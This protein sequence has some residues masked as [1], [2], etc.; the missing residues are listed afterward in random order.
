MRCLAW[1]PEGT[2]L[3]MHYGS[4]VDDRVYA[5]SI[6]SP[7]AAE[8]IASMPVAA[9]EALAAPGFL[10]CP[11]AIF[12]L[13][14]VYI[15]ACVHHAI[16]EWDYRVGQHRLLG[17]S[18]VSLGSPG[19]FY[20]NARG[21]DVI[22]QSG[23]GMCFTHLGAPISRIS[24][25]ARAG[26]RW[27]CLT[28]TDIYCAVVRREPHLVLAFWSGPHSLEVSCDVTIDEAWLTDKRQMSHRCLSLAASSRNA[29]SASGLYRAAFLRHEDKQCCTVGFLPRTVGHA[30]HAKHST[31]TRT[32][33]SNI[34]ARPDAP[35]P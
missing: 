30:Q 32:Q 19:A 25:L 26:T 15:G 6:W 1:S 17:L 14:A 4:N 29:L 12:L 18:T 28:D 31:H 16:V 21:Q 9:V 11:T 34:T 23:Q 2:A 3:I 27:H 24:A 8:Y 33:W 13:G 10:R 5:F 22:W 20:F 35:A 7:S